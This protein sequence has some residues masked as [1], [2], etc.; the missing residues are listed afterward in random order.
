[1]SEPVGT[2]GGAARGPS[3]LEIAMGGG[4]RFAARLEQ[5]ADAKELHDDAAE[6]HQQALS[7]L[8]LGQDVVKANQTAQG[9]LAGAERTLANAQKRGAEIEE[10]GTAAAVQI[11][12]QATKE[13]EAKISE[14]QQNAAAMTAEAEALMKAAT[15]TKAQAD[16]LMVSAKQADEEVK[17]AEA[18]VDRLEA[19]TKADRDYVQQMRG[20]LCDLQDYIDRALRDIG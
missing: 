19:R 14:A 13:A 10:K 20:K 18:A 4:K 11:G 9:K 2:S 17:L 7:D 3:D 15:E 8:N 1:M 16:A 5:L 12:K 6:R